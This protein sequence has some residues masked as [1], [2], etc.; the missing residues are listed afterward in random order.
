MGRLK[1]LIGWFRHWFF[2]VLL[3]VLMFSAIVAVL[4]AVVLP[5]FVSDPV[6]LWVMRG[7][8]ILSVALGAASLR[9][10][11]PHI[12]GLIA[13]Y[14]GAGLFIRDWPAYIDR[15][16]ERYAQA[17]SHIWTVVTEWDIH[18]KLS[19]VLRSNRALA[20]GELSVVF[21]GVVEKG[22]HFP[23]V[24][25]RLRLNREELSKR[26]RILHVPDINFKYILVD[27]EVIVPDQVEGREKFKA[28]IYGPKS[29][30]PDFFRDEFD[31]KYVGMKD[32][33]IVLEDAWS[34]AVEIVRTTMDE[35]NIKGVNPEL[36]S[37][38]VGFRRD[39]VVKTYN[40][41]DI[42]KQF[43]D[44]L[45]WFIDQIRKNESPK[46]GPSHGVSS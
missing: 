43:E 40:G 41:I 8:T 15:S 34:K 13:L 29:G 24:L 5:P 2:A 12:K 21:V 26:C 36:T 4:F 14:H 38:L 45:R 32:K 3:F 33:D 6:Y 25:W 35:R 42:I 44:D 7:L 9:A 30:L 22:L 46:A 23:G 31:R 18:E 39:E 16:A 37:A 11:M 28:Y 10:G 1:R 27:N 17:E 20:K 19:H